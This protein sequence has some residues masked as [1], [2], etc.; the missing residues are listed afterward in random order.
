MTLR[1]EDVERVLMQHGLFA[2]TPSYVLTCTCD[3]HSEEHPCPELVTDL[4][5]LPGQPPPPSRIDSELPMHRRCF[6]CTHCMDCAV[7]ATPKPKGNTA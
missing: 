4:C 6:H 7:C 3:I 1:R 2:G 5:A